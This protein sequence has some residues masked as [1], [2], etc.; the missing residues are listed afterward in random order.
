MARLGKPVSRTSIA[1]E[2]AMS[3]GRCEEALQKLI[4]ALRQ[5]TDSKAVRHLAAAWIE[6]IGLPPGAA[7]ALRRGA[8]ALREDWLDI[9]SMVEAVQGQ[10]KLYAEAVTETAAHFGCSER[11]VQSCV[12]DLRRASRRDERE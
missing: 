2:A 8:P 4:H 6:R 7:K 12:A 10:G 9:A 5:D 3:E 1:I 11:H